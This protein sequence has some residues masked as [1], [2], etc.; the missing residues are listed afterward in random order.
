M[1]RIILNG[2]LFAQAD[3]FVS[4]CSVARHAKNA[5]TVGKRHAPTSY[6]IRADRKYDVRFA[7]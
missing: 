2:R 3:S 1:Y 4:A 5:A 6:V 7:A